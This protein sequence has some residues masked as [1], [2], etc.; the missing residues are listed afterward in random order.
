MSHQEFY[1]TVQ[2]E[3]E[4]S[5]S[6]HFW[7]KLRRP[8]KRALKTISAG[9]L[10]GMT[11]ISPQWRYEVMTEVFG[12]V[13]I[14]WKYSI[15]RFW[16]ESASSDQVM[17]FCMINLYI[18]VDELW[19]DPIPGVGGSMLVAQEKNGLHSSDEAYK[20]ALTDALSVS[21][22][23][24]GVAADIYSGLWDGSKYKDD[25]SKSA[26]APVKAAL[27]GVEINEE[28]QQ[29]LR[30]LAA[31]LVQNI[32]VENDIRTAFG[33]WEKAMLD[34]D[35]KLYLWDVLKPNSKTRSAIKREIDAR[36]AAF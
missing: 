28:D 11:D 14:G 9:R 5:M 6:L 20:M 17:A 16:T 35:Q 13:G 34:N 33:K 1:E 26:I 10:R 29:Y 32:E 36:K 7:D 27:Q 2:R 15:E 30:D 21:M 22:K 3:E 23:Q 24:L 8:P 4:G 12:P 19:S 25:A 31:E 18:K